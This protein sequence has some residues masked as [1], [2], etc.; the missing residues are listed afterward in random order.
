MTEP[1][2]VDLSQQRLN[3]RETHGAQTI[4]FIITL[5][6]IVVVGCAIV[7]HLTADAMG[8]SPDSRGYLMAG[9]YL[10]QGKGI[11]ILNGD[12]KPVPLTHYAPLY[13]I[14]LGAAG[15]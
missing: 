11:L 5:L 13:P 6:A 9:R 3:S 14:L 1:V 7:L 8:V 10:A 4:L 2:T 12:G 15:L